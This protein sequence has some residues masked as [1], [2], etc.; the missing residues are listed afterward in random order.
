VQDRAARWPD[1]AKT[2]ALLH[3]REP[4]NHELARRRGLLLARLGRHDE[5]RPLLEGAIA[6]DPEDAELRLAIAQGAQAGGD[7]VTALEHLRELLAYHPGHE[8]GLRALI[9][10]LMEEGRWSEVPPQLEAWVA[11]HPGDS[12][13]RYN[14][15]TAYLKEFQ[16]NLARPHYNI[17][18][19]S[20]P[21]H[22]RSL[23]PYFP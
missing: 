22:A 13:A 20:S 1:L 18:R 23:A 17:L 6:K 12:R 4:G 11:D 10:L 8:A 16:P 19:E 14:L 3:E 15:I 5:A 9:E 2:L 7:S 21:R